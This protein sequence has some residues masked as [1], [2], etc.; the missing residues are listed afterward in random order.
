MHKTFRL[1]FLFFSISSFSQK[2]H[3]NDWKKT[4]L[5]LYNNIY[6]AGDSK[7]HW[8]F[9]KIGTEWNIIQMK[10]NKNSENKLE[11]PWE[12]IYKKNIAINSYNRKVK[13]I[14]N[15]YIVG[16]NNGEF[17]GGLFVISK[18]GEKITE[19]NCCM[20]VQEIFQFNNK[21]FVTE[22]SYNFGSSR[23]AIFEIK[24]EQDWIYKEISK[25]EGIPIFT[26]EH[27]RNKLIITDKHI[28]K[29]DSRNEITTILTS[30]FY[31]GMLYPSNALIDGN[32]I[33]LSM[34]KGI[35]RIISFENNPRY[36][37]YIPKR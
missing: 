16:V 10:F 7:E 30:H 31:W 27:N 9:E 13:K 36:E 34:R 14:G 21:I 28:L 26:V 3:L 17:G 4:D 2:P 37:W 15:E 6:D 11:L 20:R 25:I 33:Y 5:P 19:L 1:F 24:K 12:K 35:L 22:M 18:N 23:G 29:L 8:T 32:D